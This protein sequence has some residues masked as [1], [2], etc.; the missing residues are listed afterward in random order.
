MY[1][2]PKDVQLKDVIAF[3]YDN[4]PG[5]AGKGDKHMTEDDCTVVLTDKGDSA[6]EDRHRLQTRVIL[7]DD[8]RISTCPS[9][10]FL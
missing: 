7:D 9:K 1:L 4:S 3:A 10:L 8:K 2:I 6:S 5:A